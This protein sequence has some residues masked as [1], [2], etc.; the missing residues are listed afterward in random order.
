MEHEDLYNKYLENEKNIISKFGLKSDNPAFTK[1]EF[2]DMDNDYRLSFQRDRDRIIH[3]RAYRRLMH[4]TQVFNA[5]TGDHY[6]NRLTHT[7]E[8]CQIARSIGKCFGLNDELIEAIA[9]GHDIGHTPFGHIGERALHE[10]ISG[11]AS[12]Y[13]DEFPQNDNGGFKHNYQSLQLADRIE[14][15]TDEYPGL[16]LTFAVREGI[17]KH[18]GSKIKLTKLEEDTV[19]YASLDLANMRVDQCSITLEGQVVAIADEIAQCSHDLEDGIRAKI[20]KIDDIKDNELIARLKIDFNKINETVDVRNHIIRSLV[21]YLID[22][23]YTNTKKELDKLIECNKLPEYKCYEDS[24]TYKVVDFSSD[25]E[26]NI[27]D[28]QK[29]LSKLI[30]KLVIASQEVTQ[31][32]RKSEYI[33]KKLFKAY[34]QYPQQL[35][36]YI[37]LRYYSRTGLPY[38][39]IKVAS[40]KS[41][42]QKDANFIRLICDHIA[43][44]TDQYASREYR[45]LYE[46]EFF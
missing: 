1:R 8:V 32:D 22:N 15:R 39:R 25:M 40:E 10:I 45:K 24:Y 27:K 7:M 5:N 36:D 33:I 31:S 21:G 42:L 34:Y 41:N 38:D 2:N 19:S 43:S 13:D 17:F 20:I 6:R 3:S 29:K 4:K 12:K 11:R 35:P 46:P 26:N 16:N 28:E 37:L 9:I 14:K 30:T 44:M 23:V 18:T